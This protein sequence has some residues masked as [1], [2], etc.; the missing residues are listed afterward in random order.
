MQAKRIYCQKRVV[1]SSELPSDAEIPS[2][3][4]TTRKDDSL[5]ALPRLHI[6]DLWA[7]ALEKEE[8]RQGSSGQE[9]LWQSPDLEERR[10]APAVRPIT[11]GQ[12]LGAGQGGE[13]D[14]CD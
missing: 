4:Q 3:T 13:L 12:G 1:C 5:V 6:P 2:S 14:R 9:G 10:A 11:P 7:S 8:G